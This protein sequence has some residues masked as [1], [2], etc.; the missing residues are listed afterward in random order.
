MAKTS[1]E[2]KPEE[3]RSVPPRLW[4]GLSLVHQRSLVALLAA[5][6]LKQMVARSA[7]L[8]PQEVQGESSSGRQ[9]AG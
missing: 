8:A 5:C 1:P 3:T 4:Q 2:S 7:D 9:S 6:V